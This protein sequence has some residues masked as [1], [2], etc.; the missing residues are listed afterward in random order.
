MKIKVKKLDETAEL[1]TKAYPGS[2]GYDLTA[3]GAEF[4]GSTGLKVYRTGLSIEIPEGYV[5]FLFPRSSVANTNLYLRNSV[6]VIDS[7]YRGEV[8]LKFSPGHGVQKI[9]HSGDKVGQLLIIKNEEL[10]FEVVDELTTTD[11]DT[12]G[13]GSS[14][15][16]NN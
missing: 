12:K 4:E 8:I 10:E 13:F 9:Y 1:P 7:D 6:G 15:E 14:D 3:I 2:A 5:G 11:R 16:Q